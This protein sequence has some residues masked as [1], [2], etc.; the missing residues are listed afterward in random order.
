[1]IGAGLAVV[2]I[3]AG[4]QAVQWYNREVLDSAMK[5]RRGL[6]SDVLRTHLK[7][8]VSPGTMRLFAFSGKVPPADQTLAQ[9]LIPL[10][11]T[12]ADL[13]S[14]PGSTALLYPSFEK[15]RSGGVNV[16]CALNAREWMI[17]A[18]DQSYGA[19][20]FS[21]STFTVRPAG[22]SA[23]ETITTG[24]HE[25]LGLLNVPL[26]SLWLAWPA[27][28]PLAVQDASGTWVY[29]NPGP[30]PLPPDCVKQL[31]ADKTGLVRMGVLPAH[32]KQFAG[33]SQSYG[34]VDLLQ[35]MGSFPM[36]IVTMRVRSVGLARGVGERGQ[37]GIVV[38]E[39]GY[40]SGGG[41]GTEEIRCDGANVLKFAPA[42]GL[43]L[44]ESFEVALS[45][46]AP[47]THY[48]ITGTGGGAVGRC[49]S[50]GCG[51]LRVANN[52]DIPV[53]LNGAETASQLN[54]AGFSF[55]KQEALTSLR[56][57]IQ[58]G[59]GAEEVIDV[60]IR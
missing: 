47:A 17:D 16:L 26:V 58:A 24:N 28:V 29:D 35:A 1:M 3:A 14:C 41:P 12:C 36:R 46:V 31:P 21:G 44:D 49:V 55:L 52:A 11:D 15:S 13:S 22:T 50:D 45:G 40:R 56:L 27:A 54:G 9:F 10:P 2:A 25:L 5:Q 53:L 18:N 8:Y 6:E 19:T 20:S 43:A 33:G 37:D 60:P 30:T 51:I 4:L 42:T 38:K 59:G 57:R 7:R 34:D 23:N 48:Q 39:C 32:V